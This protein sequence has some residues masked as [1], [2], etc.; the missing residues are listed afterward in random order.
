M[1]VFYGINVEIVG[2]YGIIL[3]IINELCIHYSKF[4][5]LTIAI[6]MLT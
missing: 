1:P 6:V 2:F 3:N 4:P 5:V